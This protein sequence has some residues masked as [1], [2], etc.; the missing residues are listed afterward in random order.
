MSTV[1]PC[2][3][4]LIE[5]RRGFGSCCHLTLYQTH[6][7][8]SGTAV[9]RPTASGSPRCADNQP[10]T[11][12]LV[13]APVFFRKRHDRARTA[14]RPHALRTRRRPWLWQAGSAPR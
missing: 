9:L 10:V 5:P 1:S 8:E 2:G 7:D 13:I 3:G 11:A 6:L 4:F 12:V 14:P